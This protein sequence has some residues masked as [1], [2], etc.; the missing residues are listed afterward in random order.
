MHMADAGTEDLSILHW[1]GGG[2]QTEE[3]LCVVQTPSTHTLQV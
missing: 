2:P 1:G 3:P